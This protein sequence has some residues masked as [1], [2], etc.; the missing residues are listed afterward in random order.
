VFAR[1]RNWPAQYFIRERVMFERIGS[2]RMADS[3]R[4]EFDDSVTEHDLRHLAALPKIKTL[5]CS[6]PVKDAVWSLLNESFFSSRPDVELRVYGHYSI[7]CDLAFARRMVN[8][9]RFAADRLMRATSVGAIAEIPALESLSLGIFELQDFGVLEAVPPTLTTLSLG[10]TRSNRPHLEALARFT[11]LKTLYIEGQSNGIEILGKLRELEDVTLRSITTPDLR[12][13]A[14]L[15]RLWS[16]DVKLGGIRSFDGIEGKGSI[17][18][19]ELWQIR[20]LEDANIV[21]SLTGLQNVFMQCLPR[22]KEL[23]RLEDC[24]TLRRAVLQ[25]MKGFADFSA[26]EAAP[27]LEEFGLLEGNRQQPAQLVPVLRNPVLRGA[28]A[29]FGSDRKNDAFVRLRE[30]HRKA[31]W[32]PWTPFEYR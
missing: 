7:E 11:S 28:K 15:Q 26:F 6:G 23:P 19:L 24:H 2:L 32:D 9:R 12:Y 10:A 22:V 25:N 27:A 5:Q 31:D 17:K 4:A 8:V 30:A 20:G 13:L 16:L 3:T 18:Y 14:P 29:L 21:A 1:K